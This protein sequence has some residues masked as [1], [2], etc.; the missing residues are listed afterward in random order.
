ML[1]VIK[2]EPLFS[3]FMS[4]VC[5]T[6]ALSVIYVDNTYIH[7]W[8]LQPFRI[9]I[10]DLVSHTTYVVCTHF[11]HKLRDLQSKSTPNDRFFEKIFMALS[12]TLRVRVFARNLLR[13]NRQRNAFRILFWCLALDSNPGFSSNKPTHDLRPLQCWQYQPFLIVSLSLT[14]KKV[15]RVLVCS[16]I[17]YF[18]RK[19]GSK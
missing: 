11:I 5:S 4:N 7:N 12:L 19:N 9:R 14:D 13:G 10:I 1:G 16:S 8:S 3:N 2:K 17:F 6:F 15:S 18:W